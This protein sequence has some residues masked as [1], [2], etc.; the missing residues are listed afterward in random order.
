MFPV[1]PLASSSLL[2]ETVS[3]PV[4]SERLTQSTEFGACLQVSGNTSPSFTD[5]RDRVSC[6]GLRAVKQQA[7]VP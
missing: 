2:Q 5:G 6:E 7:A 1:V 3:S 4:P